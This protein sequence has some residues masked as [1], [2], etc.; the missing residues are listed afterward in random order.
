M[1]WHEQSW[2]G[3]DRVD[4]ST[5]V[6]IPLG[7]CEQHG[8]HLPLF[9]DTIQVTRIAERVEQRLADRVLL[10][11]T[12]WLGSSHHHK[13]FPG[14]VSVLP[15]LYAQMIAQVATSVLG[16]G[17]ERLFF[18]NGHGGNRVPAADA[19]SELVAVDDTADN[20]Y[21]TLASWWEVGAEGMRPE[22]L[23]TQQPGVAHACEFETSLMLALRPDLV[24]MNQI[25]P[26]TPALANDWYHSDVGGRQR[27]SVFRRYHRFSA[28]GHFGEPGAATEARGQ[29]IFDGVT[30][31]VVAFLEDF[32]TWPALPPRG[33]SSKQ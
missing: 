15:S 20:A 32:A 4:R 27:V 22:D 29:A 21:L 10:L 30:D 2:A 16:A 6:L 18:L 24:A 5:P 9:V 23:A 8:H 31:R 28:A 3:L 1:L 26:H 7:S 13:D 14:T 17:F 19:L 33:P 25:A 11:P 12:L